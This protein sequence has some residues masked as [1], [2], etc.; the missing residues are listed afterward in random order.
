MHEPLTWEKDATDIY[1]SSKAVCELWQYVHLVCTEGQRTVRGL[2]CNPVIYRGQ[3]HRWPLLPRAARPGI[4]YSAK[5]EIASLKELKLRS[6]LLLGSRC[7]ESDIEWLSLA[8]HH[9]MPTRL[10]D[11][12]ENALAALWFAVHERPT[13]DENPVV[14]RLMPATRDVMSDAE[15]RER[16]AGRK[17]RRTRVIYSNHAHERAR[18]QSAWFTLHSPEPDDEYQPLEKQPDFRHRTDGEYAALARIDIDPSWVPKLRGELARCGISAASVYPDMG[19]LCQRI[20][21]QLPGW[22]SLLHQKWGDDS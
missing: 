3:R 4:A 8:Q 18:A 15:W 21:E 19:G 16:I 14:W 22:P 6:P 1:R 9:G 12:T 5:L 2:I 13:G 17:T 11:W 20:A 7:P 10:L